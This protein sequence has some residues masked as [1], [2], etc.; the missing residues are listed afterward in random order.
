MGKDFA[1]NDILQHRDPRR[2]GCRG[3]YIGKRAR[4]LSGIRRVTDAIVRS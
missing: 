3:C 4:A 2:S 1:F